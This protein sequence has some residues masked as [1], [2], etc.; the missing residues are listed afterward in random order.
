M[1]TVLFFERK[2]TALRTTQFVPPSLYDLNTN[3][4]EPDFQDPNKNYSIRQPKK[5]LDTGLKLKVPDFE[6]IRISFPKFSN[7]SYHEKSV[8]ME[9][10]MRTFDHLKSSFTFTRQISPDGPMILSKN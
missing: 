6:I 1:S 10:T 9:G 4:P 3:F 5:V 8:S 2:E 7:R